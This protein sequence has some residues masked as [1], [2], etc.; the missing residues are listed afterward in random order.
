MQNV[1]PLPRPRPVNLRQAVA[2]FIWVSFSGFTSAAEMQE[3]LNMSLEELLQVK[4]SSGSRT[5]NRQKYQP[6]SITIIYREDIE[7]AYA[8][9]LNDLLNMYVPGYF[10][11]EDKDDTIAAFRGLAPDNNSKVLFLINGVKVNADWFWG[12]ADNILNG[13]DLDY[14]ERIEVVRGPGSVTLGQGAQLGVINIITRK[15]SASQL[16]VSAGDAGWQQLATLGGHTVEQHQ[17]NWYASKQSLDG[18]TLPARGWA[19][20]VVESDSSHPS[21][22]SARGNRLNR[23]EAMRLLLDYQY[24][25]LTVSLQHHQQMRDLY[26]WTKDRDQVEQRLTVFAA[27]YGQPLNQQWRY[28]LTADWQQDDYALYDHTFN[29]TTGGA[30]EV[31]LS[32]TSSAT[33]QS[34]NHD[35]TWTTGFELTRIKTGDANWQGDN[36][37]VNQTTDVNAQ[38]NRLNTWVFDNSFDTKAMFTELS[39]ELIEHWVFNLG[40][41][42]DDHPNWGEQVSPRISAIYK[43]QESER[44][45]RLT[46]SEGFRGAPGVHYSGGFLRDGL[47]SESNFS[48]LGGTGMTSSTTGELL[49]SLPTTQPEQLNVFELGVRGELNN[50]WS[51]DFVYYSSKIDNIIV[52]QSTRNGT[53]EAPVGT[54]IVGLWGG[55]FYYTNTPEVLE[56][57]G[58]EVSARY[59]TKTTQHNLSYSQSKIISA[60]GFSFGQKSPV[61]GDPDSIHSNGMPEQFLRYQGNLQIDSNWQVAYQHIFIGDWYSPWTNEKAQGFGWGNATLTWQSE[62]QHQLTLKIANIW[63]QNNLYPI[64]E[65]GRNNNTA[66]TPTLEERSFKLNYIFT[67]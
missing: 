28:D 49:M 59:R 16:I 50:R 4:V 42:F 26:N 15:E 10:K 38:N 25:A 45:Y 12:P 54:D 43:S 57:D 20:E 52:T 53:P 62:R 1:S 67:F 11:S 2:L 31:R 18:F 40:A 37:I 41:R 29:L 66:G 13:I 35:T 8:R 17:F 44:Y 30:R 5:E 22:P 19:A 23:S 14:I 33:W 32:S 48:E 24:N 64:R 9:T 34:V 61:A 27:K 7:Q 47:L 56:I 58:I 36:F 3:L 60:D 21:T 65:R 46:Y 39:T 63:Q 51:Y 6:S 55:V